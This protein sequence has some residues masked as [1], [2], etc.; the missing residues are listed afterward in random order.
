MDRHDSSPEDESRF[1]PFPVF[2]SIN[3]VR[4][5]FLVFSRTLILSGSVDIKFGADMYIN[6]LGDP[7]TPSAV[8][9]ADQ[10]LWFGIKF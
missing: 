2:F 7:L 9:Q 5:K 3:T 1:W 8:A 10:L 6:D 4:L